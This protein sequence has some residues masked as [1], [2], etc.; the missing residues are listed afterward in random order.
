MIEYKDLDDEELS[1][2]QTDLIEIMTQQADK[3]IEDMQITFKLGKQQISII[4]RAADLIGIP[5]QTYIKESAVRQS[6]SDIEKF[7]HILGS[8]DHSGKIVR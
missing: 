2:E 8:L 3:D 7:S 4:K 6:V 5:Y 1:S